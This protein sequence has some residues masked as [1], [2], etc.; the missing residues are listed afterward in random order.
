MDQKYYYLLDTN[1]LGYYAELKA[2]CETKESNA[3]QMH[4]ARVPRDA[5]IFLCPISAGEVE[6]GLKIGPY[7]ETQKQNQARD[8]LN[9]FP[10]LEINKSIAME[11]Y[12]D[13]RAKLYRKFAPISRKNKKRCKKRIEEWMD[14]TTSEKLQVQEN[15]LWISAVALA[16]NLIL[17]THDM[18]KPI[19][20]VLG[21]ELKVEDWL[22]D[23]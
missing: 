4:L 20:S 23:D 9:V 21:A 5:K 2:G 8:I 15:D 16:Y 12:A 7:R 3:L 18:M 10:Y 19:K 13:L 11:Y 14:P 22:I 6:Y 1:I 17:V